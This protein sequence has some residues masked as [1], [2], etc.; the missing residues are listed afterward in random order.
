MDVSE[1]RYA[2]HS[3]LAI[4]YQVSGT[5]DV[6]LVVPGGPATHLD[7]VFELPGAERFIERLGHFARVIR[8]DRRGTGLSDPVAGPPTL[9][10]QADDLLAVMDAVGCEKAALFGE[11]EG[12]RLCAMVAASHPD[13]VSS[14]MLWAAS[15]RGSDV[16]KPEVRDAMLDIVEQSWGRGQ[17]TGLFAPTRA[18]DTAFAAAM[19]RFERAALSPS[20]ARALI[21]MGSRANVADVLPL[22]AVPTLV[23]HRRDDTLVPA[24]LGREVADLIPGARFVEFDGAD[25]MIFVGENDSILDEMEEFLTGQR[26]EREADRA[27]L[28]VMFTDVVDSTARASELGD[29]RWRQLLEEHDRLVRRELARARGREVKT[30]GDGFLATFDGP[31]RAIRCARAVRDAMRALGIEVRAGLHTG[32][33][34]L[35]GDDIGG[36]AVHIAARV[37]GA[38]G[39]GEVLVSS[40]VKDLV[41]GS[42]LEFED[43]GAHQ[44]KGVPGEW[45][46]FAA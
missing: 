3:S 29:T 1:T 2:S 40:T 17:M 6:D 31:A 32:E 33:C 13:R 46:L 24:H 38:A 43:R 18:G 25:D 41:F 10:Q 22:I 20:M 12:T 36:L 23:L 28:T 7:A 4:A 44:L 26:T 30:V 9:E 15:A 34:E 21:D 14:L 39:P 27:L 19:A 16:M 42:G 45:R 8:F 35:L 5:G 11:G 37:N